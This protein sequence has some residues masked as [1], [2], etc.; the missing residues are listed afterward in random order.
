[1]LY[2]FAHAGE[3]GFARGIASVISESP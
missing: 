1:M 3:E 2:P